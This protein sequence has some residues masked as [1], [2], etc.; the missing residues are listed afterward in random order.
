MGKSRLVDEWCKRQ[1]VK[2]V[3]YESMRE[4]QRGAELALFAQDAARSTLTASPTFAGV[5]PQSWEAAFSLIA[6]Q[7][8]KHEPSIVVL[9]EFPYLFES[10]P[11][12]EAVIQRIWDRHIDKKA[13][14][15]VILIGSDLH[16]MEQLG[17]YDRPLFGRAR[18]LVVQPL[19]PSDIADMTG[20]TGADALDAYLICGGFPMLAERWRH[21]ESI[22]TYLKREL[23]P[24]A[25]LIVNGERMLSSEFPVE[26]QARLIL[27]V[28]GSGETTFK[29]IGQKSGVN[30][31]GVTRA[32]DIL[33]RKRV[34]EIMRPVSTDD[35]PRN[36]R[37]IVADSY[38]RF[39]LRFIGSAI[40]EIERGSAS[41]VLES[42]RQGW[43]QYRGQAIE[44][45]I[46]HALVRMHLPLRQANYVGAYWTRT[47][48]VQV[49]L[50]GVRREHGSTTVEFVGSIK[51]R[52][53]ATLDASDV[54]K[55]ARD[56]L[57]VPGATESTPMIAVSRVG[58][59]EVRSLR[60]KVGP[61]DVVAAFRLARPLS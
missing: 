59:G 45:L 41:V 28:I 8:T 44:P 2:H 6:S 50:V 14:V 34:I 12:I 24:T 7:S 33:N 3:F 39:W 53:E 27:E 56:R 17:Q 36:T 20:L 18:E 35:A 16:M 61:E 25:P 51:W 54:A 4:R 47:N 42:I 46:R 5:T 23:T 40:S 55:L 9:D 43:K 22:W 21:G 52:E 11:N 10:E 13:P 31:A 30:G 37:Y 32:I 15:F 48:D 29:N 60:L 49:D 57:K 19:S 26:A 38:L 58:F 1:G